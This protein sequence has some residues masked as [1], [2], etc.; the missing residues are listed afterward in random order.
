MFINHGHYIPTLYFKAYRYLIKPKFR[1]GERVLYN[2]EV[3]EILTVTGI[4][5]PYVYFACPVSNRKINQFNP[6][7]KQSYLK[8]INSLY[9]ELT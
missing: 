6:Y 4:N 9:N 1:A 2:G 5:P 3:L 8:K 7:I